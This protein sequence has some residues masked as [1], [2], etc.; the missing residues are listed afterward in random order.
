MKGTATDHHGAASMQGRWILFT[1]LALL[2]L[3]SGVGLCGCGANSTV[4]LSCKAPMEAKTS[5]GVIAS[6]GRCD[7]LLGGK[8]AHVTL[9]PG[10]SVVFALLQRSGLGSLSVV[11]GSTALLQP[12]SSL[13]SVAAFIAVRR[14]TDRMVATPPPVAPVSAASAFPAA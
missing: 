2:V 1:T 11:N 10:Q 12:I 5:N 8:V 6:I 9:K 3:G 13:G 14:G 7:G 4:S